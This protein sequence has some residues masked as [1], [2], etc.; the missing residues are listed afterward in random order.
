MPEVYMGVMG[1]IYSIKVDLSF[2]KQLGHASH[3]MGDVVRRPQR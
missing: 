2:G 3:E 1:Y